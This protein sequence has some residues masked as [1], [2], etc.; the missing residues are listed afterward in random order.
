MN[1]VIISNQ[2]IIAQRRIYD[3]FMNTMT[4]INS[5]INHLDGD[6]STGANQGPIYEIGRAHV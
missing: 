3:T 1:L 6:N 4:N 5:E 2:C